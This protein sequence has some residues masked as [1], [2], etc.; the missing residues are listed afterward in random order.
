MRRLLTLLCLL[1]VFA[2]AQYTI[3]V[4][5][6]KP[7]SVS[8]D[9]IMPAGKFFVRSDLIPQR[10][11]A[12]SAAR[13][14]QSCD[15]D[16]PGDCQDSEHPNRYSIANP[17]G[18]FRTLCTFSHASFD[19]PIVQP[20]KPGR[21]HLHSFFGNTETS[22]ATDAANMTTRG[23]STCSGGIL[24]RTGYWIPTLIYSCPETATGCDHSRNGTPIFPQSSNFYYKCAEGYNCNTGGYGGTPL[25]WWPAGF[26]M[27]AGDANGTS[28]QNGSR[29]WIECWNQAIQNPSNNNV[30]VRFSHI[31]TYAETSGFSNACDMLEITITFPNCWDGVNLDSPTHKAHVD[32]GD[33][34]LG[35]TNPLFPILTP[36]L[37]FNVHVN[38]TQ[39]DLDYLRLSSDQPA[40]SG[41]PGGYT[42]H[43]DW[44]NGWN[45]DDNFQGWGVGS[46]T[47]ILKKQCYA[48]GY[49]S[50]WT[51]GAAPMH[52]DCHDN[53]LGN[54]N[55][56]DSSLYYTLY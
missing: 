41:I 48:V 47:D 29:F 7:A 12:F 17:S 20:G 42:L 30:G 5:A 22:F 53:L 24:N 54:P 46:L 35:C 19:D 50:G 21:T 2:A 10:R 33:F 36:T 6:T 1:P 31:P 32:Y 26:R 23:N 45:Q 37:S 9:Y 44:A 11:Y 14:E 13:V 16:I 28:P 52:T 15:S 25:R 51:E 40:S 4:P 3:P 34:Y 43:G 55:P 49:T 8:P 18:S 27:I 38:I 56:A 39:T